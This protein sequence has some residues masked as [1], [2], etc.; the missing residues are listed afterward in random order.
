MGRAKN[1]SV[2]LKG[3]ALSRTHA[4]LEREGEAWVLVDA[5]SRNGLTHDDIRVDRLTLEN[6]T[7]VTLGDVGLRVRLEVLEEQAAG[8]AVRGARETMASSQLP[9]APPAPQPAPLPASPPGRPLDDELDEIV[10]EGEFT[11]PSP[12]TPT[13]PARPA[14]SASPPAASAPLPPAGA[15]TQPAASARD[16]AGLRPPPAN[17]GGRPVLQYSQV[18]D[19]RGFLGSDLAQHPAWVRLVVGLGVVAAAAGMGY[20]VFA[21]VKTLRGAP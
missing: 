13:A 11:D 7:E 19:R 9:S 4:R 6:G 18:P 2:S 20:L 12:T 14:S 8:E 16:R 17:S 5:G 3:N 21:V 1:C 15:S 10:L